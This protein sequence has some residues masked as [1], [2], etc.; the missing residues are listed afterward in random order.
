MQ[1]L[2]RTAVNEWGFPYLKLD[3]LYAA[4]LPGQRHD[5]AVTRAQ[6]MRLA[7]SD[8]RAAAGPETFLL[9]CGCPLGPAVGLVDGMRVSTDV[10]PAWV[11][12]LLTPGL[13]PLLRREMDFVGVRNAL[14][15]TINRAPLHRRW[16]LNDPDCLLVRDHDTDLTEAEVRSLATVIALSGGMFLVSDDMRRLKPERQRYIAALLPVLDVSARAPG[17]MDSEMPDLFVLPLSGAAG[18]WVVAGVFNWS[19]RSADRSLDLAALGLQPDADYY[20][21]DFWD[22]ETWQ[23]PAHQPLHLAALPPHGARLL[24]LRR[25]APAPALIASDF[26]FSQGCEIHSWQVEP[27]A[28]TF[29][30]V[31]GR[32]AVGALRLA[33][34]AAPRR[35]E[36]E[37]GA[38][39]VLELGQG[40]YRLNLEVN[41]SATVRVEW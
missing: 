2:I 27:S 41:G 29:T 33:L 13:A 26:H 3:F 24:A 39:A 34:P 19:A 12:S 36:M 7:L 38:P 9:G 14:R 23:H 20:V 25:R 31:L 18:D 28:L 40:Q 5:P 8:I 6:A 4:A 16:W 35:V 21:S 10:A 1:R 37:S 32:R 15:N 22:Q 30:V 11:S 17:W